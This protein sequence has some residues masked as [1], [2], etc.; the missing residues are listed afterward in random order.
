[1]KVNINV[2]IDTENQTDVNTI[3]ELIE[4]IKQIKEQRESDS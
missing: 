3:D 2:E 4:L 1:M